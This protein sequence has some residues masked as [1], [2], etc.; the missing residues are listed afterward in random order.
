[1]SFRRK[2]KTIK[3]ITLGLLNTLYGIICSLLFL[4]QTGKI[5]L[6]NFVDGYEYTPAF[7]KMWEIGLFVLLLLSIV[8]LVLNF[9]RKNKSN[10]TLFAFLNG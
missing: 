7:E 8:L 10:K 3:T 5:V 1:M 4:I 2:E 6:W 9:K